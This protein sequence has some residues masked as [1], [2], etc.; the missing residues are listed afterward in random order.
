MCKVAVS[1]VDI[2]Q[3]A[4]V[5]LRMLDVQRFAISDLARVEALR[6]GRSSLMQVRVFERKKWD[7]AR[8]VLWGEGMENLL[9]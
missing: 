3:N 1:G 8:G 6:V 9:C 7:E 4:S 2:Y 5:A